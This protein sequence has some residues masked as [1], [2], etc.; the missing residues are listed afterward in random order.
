MVNI[1]SPKKTQVK[2]G[3][4]ISPAADAKNLADHAE[5]VCNITYFQPYQKSTEVGTPSTTAENNALSFHHSDMFCAFNWNQPK[6]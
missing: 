4:T 5:P 6:T 2:T 3:N 1:V